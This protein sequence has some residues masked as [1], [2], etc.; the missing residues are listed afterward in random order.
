MYSTPSSVKC[1]AEILQQL[2]ARYNDARERN[3]FCIEVRI[4]YLPKFCILTVI[5]CQDPFEID[6][7]VA[8]CVT[9]DGLYT[10]GIKGAYGSG[11][12]HLTNI[13]TDTW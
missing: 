12:L 4:L 9:K 7:N 11:Y 8:R 3:R 10:V 2:S 5:A 13:F 6:Y 1:C